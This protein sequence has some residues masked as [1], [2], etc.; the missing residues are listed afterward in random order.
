MAGLSARGVAFSGPV[1]DHGY[2]LVAW[3]LAPCD[4][5]IQLDQPR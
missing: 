1:E 2:G 4:L 3:I 5:R